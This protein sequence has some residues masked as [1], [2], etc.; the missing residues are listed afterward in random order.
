MANTGTNLAALRDVIG[1]HQHK[2]PDAA[3]IVM[4]DFNKTKLRQVM[5]NFHQHVTC[6][7]SGNNTLDHCYTQFKQGY[8]PVL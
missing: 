2:H 4:G 3:F 6:P 8:K 5:P 7:T 1:D